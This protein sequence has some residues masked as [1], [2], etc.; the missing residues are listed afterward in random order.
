MSHES[1]P[2]ELPDDDDLTAVGAAA[3]VVAAQTI[4]SDYQARRAPNTLRRQLDDLQLFC[5]YLA[6]AQVHKSARGLF[7]NPLAWSGTTAGLV[8]GFVHWQLQQGYSITSINSRLAT[9]K[10]YCKLA[11]DAG[12]LSPLQL[13]RISLIKSYRRVDGRNIDRER[14]TTRVGA[15]KAVPTLL[16]AGHAEL[17]TRQPDTRIGRRDAFMMHLFLELGLRCGELR[18]LEVQHL[19]LTTGLLTFYREKVDKVQR[20]QLS[21][22][23]LIAAMAYLPDVAHQTYLFPGRPEKATGAAQHL[24]ERSIHDRVRTL[25]TRIGLPTLGPHDLRHHWATAAAAHKTD[26]KSL[27]DAGGWSSPAMPLRYIAS[28]EIANQGVK[29]KPDSP[30]GGTPS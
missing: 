11:V 13:A 28:S 19:D 6:Y 12:T 30:H 23:A 10:V 24:D 18:D 25:G 22:A 2:I 29:L 17:L 1:L 7:S 9:I 14:T 3:D 4:F 26:V 15:K 5:T 21:S 20:H 27:Q 8:K 16:N